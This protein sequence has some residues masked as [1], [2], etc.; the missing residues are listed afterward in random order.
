[1]AQTHS[2]DADVYFV[3]AQSKWPFVG[4]IAMFVL[5]IGVASWL[6]DA[7]WG[8]WTF[9]VGVVL[10]AATLFM[11]FGDVIR[12][13][14]AGRYN[15]Q[16]DVSFRM[17]MVWFIFSEVMFFAA[18]FG[19]LFYTRTFSLPWLGGQGDGVMTN[20]LLWEGYS[21]GWPTNGPAMVGGTFQ[22]IPA[23]GLPLINTLILLTS[24]V[25]LTIGHHALK[26]AQ[27]GTVLLWL[28]ITVLLGLTFL[29][30][31]VTEYA[32]AYHAL[33]LTLGSGIYG[34]TFFM[35][36]GFHGAHVFLGTL[37][38]AIMWLRVLKG[39]F[40]KDHHFAFEAAAWYWHF[41]DVVWLALFL[42]VYV[43]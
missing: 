2:Q 41:V 23:W 7:A 21:A 24:G 36:T 8:K 40:T 1:M 42:F 11:W 22:T 19:A 29:Y 35:L 17:G 30:F 14:V 15:G 5:M 6:N 4:S 34:S 31:Q 12:E 43:L 37:M 33:N 10:L 25:T 13:S 27:R 39:H 3:P 9:L 16:V 26:A 38:L 20:A 32:H 18:F 28:G